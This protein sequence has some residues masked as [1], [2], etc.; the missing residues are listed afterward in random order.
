MKIN[1]VSLFSSAGIGELLLK[2]INVNVVL[3]N[4][5]DEKRLACHKYFYPNCKTIIGDICD[6]DIKNEI[7]KNIPNDTNLLIATPPCQGLSTIGKNRVQGQFEE[8]KRN[9]L[10]LEIFDIIDKVD[11][12]YILIENV[13]KF[14]RMY[15]PYCGN[16]L[17]LE[18]IL[19]IKYSDN[20]NIDI[21]I[22]NAKDY[23][24]PQTRPRAIIKMYKKHLSWNNPKKQNEIT[25]QES[26]GHLPS[27]EIG[28]KSTLK[29]HYAKKISDRIANALRHTPTGKSALENDIHYPIKQDGTRIKGFHNTY[30]RMS[31]NQPAHART[32][33]S[34]SVS[35]HNNVHP[36]R[37]LDNGEYSDPRV[38]SLLETFIVTSIPTNIEFPPNSSETFI[39]KMIGE[40]IPPLLLN[41]IIRPIFKEV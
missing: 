20:Y 27:L 11:F 30:K 34:G 24:V 32:T 23:G 1:A 39:R 28:E 36:G 9:F 5:I 8:D 19:N 40:S 18:E 21:G 33:Y 16:Y 6:F 14:I 22:L 4:D 10:V 17:T 15:F 3:S 2:N 35:S 38:L 31:W 12:D 37:L 29:W 26:I 25:L 7:I 13:P 41:E